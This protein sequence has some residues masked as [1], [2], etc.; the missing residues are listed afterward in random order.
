[1]VIHKLLYKCGSSNKANYYTAVGCQLHCYF[2]FASGQL[3]CNP[4]Y[5][6]RP[7]PS[8]LLQNFSLLRPV[9]HKIQT[10][11]HKN[12]GISLLRH[13]SGKWGNSAHPIRANR[14]HPSFL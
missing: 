6:P 5:R 14:A 12:T 13:K 10:K 2:A 9:V 3:T 7:S 11:T 4:L 8:M 1:M